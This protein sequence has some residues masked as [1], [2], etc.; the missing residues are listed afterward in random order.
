M[1]FD[2]TRHQNRGKFVENWAQILHPSPNYFAA[3]LAKYLG[4]WENGQFSKTKNVIKVWEKGAKNGLNLQKN[5][6]MCACC[7]TVYKQ[8][9]YPALTLLSDIFLKA[10]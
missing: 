3:L 1:I 7:Q 2:I 4:E 9:Q 6:P 5:D 8:I 10:G